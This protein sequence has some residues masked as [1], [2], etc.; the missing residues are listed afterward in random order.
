MEKLKELLRAYNENE[1]DVYIN[2]CNFL[3]NKKNKEGQLENHWMQ[4]RSEKV[5]ADYF[6]LVK[7][8]GLEF[9]GKHITL[10]STGVS[11][12][13]IA[14]KNKMFLSYPESILD[15]NLVREGD[16]YKFWKDSG[17]VFYKHNINDPFG[18]NNV[19]GGYCVI[20]NKRG[21]FITTLSKA[22][23]EKH[24]KVAKT[25][26]IWKDWWDEMALKTVIKKACKIH[27]SDIFTDMEAIDNENYDLET[28]L[29]LDIKTIEEV[30]SIKTLEDLEKYYKENKTKNSGLIREFNKIV[31]DQKKEIQK[32]QNDN[33]E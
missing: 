12:D 1:V 6:K 32:Q 31:T 27:F 11:Y 29:E 13:Y 7:N 24:Q 20:K 22:D 30:K 28:P 3:K 4:H 2:Y 19:L 33:K 26:K 5:L 15:I 21:E 10:Q 23:I 18:N 17:K 14:Y 8:D 9:D 25:Q 16:E